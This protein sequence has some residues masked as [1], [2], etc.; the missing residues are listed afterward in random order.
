MSSKDPEHPRS[1]R[2]KQS[3]NNESQGAARP[4]GGMF[5]QMRTLIA[6]QQLGMLSAM[7]MWVQQQPGFT[8]VGQVSDIE[9]LLD[10]AEETQPD[11]VLL[12]WELHGQ[13][14]SDLITA[15]HALD[16]QPK[17]VVLSVKLEAEETAMAAGADAFASK[18]DPPKR[19]LA[20]LHRMRLE[21]DAEAPKWKDHNGSQGL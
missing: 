4:P 5:R 19:L 18:R 10:Q 11:L 21:K 6:I 12:D 2:Q 9:S 16:S 8:L 1:L 7:S 15:L 14:G 3:S 13:P 20:A 17:V